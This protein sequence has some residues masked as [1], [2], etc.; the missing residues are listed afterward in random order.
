MRQPTVDVHQ[1]AH[2]IRTGDW[3]NGDLSTL[4]EAIKY[5]RAQMVKDVK[6]S[7]LVGA[8]VT[9]TDSRRGRTASGTVEKIGRTYITVRETGRG[10][11]RVP[12]SMIETV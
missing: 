3:T 11:W 12:A 10:L 6:R 9:F 8:A 7:V 1:L 2:A 5:R 4:V